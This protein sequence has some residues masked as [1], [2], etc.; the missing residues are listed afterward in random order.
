MPEWFEH[1]TS[2]QPTASLQQTPETVRPGI[3]SGRAKA[4]LRR[5]VDQN[6]HDEGEL[7]YLETGSP[8]MSEQ[9]ETE[10]KNIQVFDNYRWRKYLQRLANKRH[11]KF[12]RYYGRWLCKNWRHPQHPDVGLAG[13]FIYNKTQVTPLLG[14]PE[15][16]VSARRIWR[17]WCAGHTEEQVTEQ[18]SQLL[19]LSG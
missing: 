6:P 2:K 12:R 16:P 9:V 15:N 8:A 14:E 3:C 18:L 7:V 19:G 17:H 11:K 1:S 5:T 10:L 13:L 4:T